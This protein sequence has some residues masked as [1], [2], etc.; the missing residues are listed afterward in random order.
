[1]S[2]GQGI[3]GGG[4][5]SGTGDAPPP[6]VIP[7]VCKCV[8]SHTPEPRVVYEWYGTPMCGTS[9]DNANKL[10]EYRHQNGGKLPTNAT[11]LYTT[12]VR[13]AV[14]KQYQAEIAV[15]AGL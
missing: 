14:D 2:F 9:R 11:R 8:K 4:T 12:L 5:F 1:M 7:L 3:F 6:P 13:N 15:K 10:L